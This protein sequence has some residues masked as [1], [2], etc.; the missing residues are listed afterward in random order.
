M[1]NERSRDDLSDGYVVNLIRAH[2]NPELHNIPPEMITLKR[3]LV[4]VKRELRKHK[5]VSV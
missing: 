1:R 2:T 3:A 5:Q 4:T